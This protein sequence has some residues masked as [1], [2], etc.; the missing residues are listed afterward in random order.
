MNLLKNIS[1]I[2]LKNTIQSKLFLKGIKKFTFSTNINNKNESLDRI[3]NTQEEGDKIF[4]KYLENFKSIAKYSNLKLLDLITTK[5]YLTGN[6][7]ILNNRFEEAEEIYEMIKKYLRPSYISTHVYCVILR[8]LG[9]CKLK[10]KKIKEGLMELE[11][12]YEYS[13][14]KKAF[15]YKLRLS[16]R[17]EL[18]NAYI[19]YDGLKAGVLAE[20]ILNDESELKLLDLEELASVYSFAAVYTY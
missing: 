1:K 17:L 15:N 2:S 7:M 6:Y 16:T 13:K 8:R 18:L 5:E 9:V 19:K 20:E 14:N 4:S 10:L 3:K 12:A 11:N